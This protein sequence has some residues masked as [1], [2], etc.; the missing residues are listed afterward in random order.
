[1]VLAA[2]AITFVFVHPPTTAPA[3]PRWRIAASVVAVIACF[4]AVDFGAAG[5]SGAPIGA[6]TTNG[7][8]DFVSA[9]GLHPP[10]V[11][12]DMTTDSAALAP[13][14]FMIASFYDLTTTP[15]VGQ[16]GPLILNSD[17]QPVW[18]RPV[19]TDVVASNLTEQTYNGQP[20]LTWWQGLVSNTGATESGEDIIVNQHYQTIATLKGQDGWVLT[21]HELVIQGD[22]AWV[23]ANKD[24]PMNLSKYGGASDGVLDDS[25][26]QEYD[27]ATGKLVYSWDALDHIPLT[28]SH[29]QPPA[30]GFP[31]DAYHVNS[32][33]LASDGDFLVSMRNT[34]A[35]Y[36]VDGKSGSIEWE[37]GGKNSSFTLPA[38]ASF[39]WQHDVKL[40]PGSQAAEIVT[41][42]DDDC[43]QITGGGTYLAPA[44][45]SRALELKLDTKTHVATL[46]AQYTLGRSVDAAYMGDAQVLPDGNVVV[47]WGSQPYISEYTSSGK[48]ILK[49]S[50]PSPDLSYRATVENWVGLPT[51]PPTGAALS[52]ASATTVY[53]SWNGAT[54]VAAWRVLAGPK[55]KDLSVVA[56]TKKTGFETAM[57]VKGA[58]KT[59]E[60]EALNG[61]GK[62]I[63]TSTP[64]AAK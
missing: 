35:A 42:F 57:T 31:W 1:L 6:Y 48:L 28:A 14:Y 21:L 10:M 58:Y 54:E 4:A 17:L 27:I 61:K 47:G 41:M 30:N 24:I 50:L 32:I 3:G 9:P 55:A 25:A 62:V 2:A 19:P 45:P 52:T 16:S 56:T 36:M 12:A 26:V 33:S 43:C 64:F 38:D 15:M 5:S 59:F 63:G 46:L 39:E 51:S 23:T 60:V 18:F 37:L 13:G 8:Y 53:A 11:T 7:A 22:D 34:W 44:G 49:A 40:G 20:V 29:A